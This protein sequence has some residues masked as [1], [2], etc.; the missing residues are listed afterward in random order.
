MRYYENR[1]P[2]KIFGVENFFCE[3]FDFIIGCK[4]EFED[5]NEKS[6]G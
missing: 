6:C 2:K 3:N 5:N 1:P 4:N